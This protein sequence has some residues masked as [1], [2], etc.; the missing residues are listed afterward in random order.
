M[1][2]TSFGATGANFCVW[3]LGSFFLSS[4]FSCS[5]TGNHIQKRSLI[6]RGIKYLWKVLDLSASFATQMISAPSK[7]GAQCSFICI[8]Y[9]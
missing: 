9:Y 2:R 6:K 1:E 8:V 5:F 3:F 7:G 4:Y